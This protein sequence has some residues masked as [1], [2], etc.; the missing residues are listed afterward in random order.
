MNPL[1]VPQ[2]PEIDK[3]RCTG[4]GQCVGACGPHLLSLEAVRWKKSSVLNQPELCTGC[5]ACAQACPFGAITLLRQRQ[6]R[7]ASELAHRAQN[8]NRS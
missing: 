4:C 1:Q 8:P 6:A 3:G 7:S 2:W 5:G